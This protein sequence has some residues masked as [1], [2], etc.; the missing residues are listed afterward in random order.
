MS[1]VTYHN[2][3]SHI[4]TTCHNHISHVTITCHTLYIDNQTH[5]THVT[6]VTHVTC[7]CDMWDL[8]VTCGCDMWHVIVIC[9]IWMWHVTCGTISHPFLLPRTH[10][11]IQTKVRTHNSVIIKFI[12]GR[13]PVGGRREWRKRGQWLR[14]VQSCWR[15]GISRAPAPVPLPCLDFQIARKCR[16]CHMLKE[17]FDIQNWIEFL[18]CK[19]KEKF[20][21]HLYKS[22]V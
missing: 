13:T 10:K 21:E 3:M 19:L 2:H 17:S 5:V 1:H 20:T 18:W 6:Y 7:D 11:F 8:V 15:F 12:E 16:S 9:D 4:T 22:F 14:S